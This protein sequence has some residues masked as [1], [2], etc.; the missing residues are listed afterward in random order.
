MWELLVWTYQA[1]KAHLCARDGGDS[2]R[3]GVSSTGVVVQ[4][5]MLG[6]S[7][8][9]SGRGSHAAAGG[10]ACDKDALRVHGAVGDRLLVETASIGQIPEWRP[11]YPPARVS[12]VFRMRK[13][14]KVPVMLYDENRNPLNACK[15][16]ITGYSPDRARRWI[17]HH[18]TV[19]RHWWQA[20]ADLHD[21]LADEQPLK[22][23]LVRGVGAQREPW[24][25]NTSICDE[26]HLP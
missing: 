18:R 17:E 20:L 7:I 3:C 2:F 15:I 22:R 16:E 24:A 5:L 14:Q 26:R 21:R 11:D 8:D 9:C 12:G 6:A 1:Q 13:G 23:W 19:Y 25:T 4:R 10:M